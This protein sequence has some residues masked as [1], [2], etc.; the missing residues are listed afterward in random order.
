[1]G[2][3]DREDSRGD[4]GGNNCSD[5]HRSGWRSHVR[6]AAYRSTTTPKRRA[7]MKGGIG[8]RRRDMEFK[9]NC[10]SSSLCSRLKER[11]PIMFYFSRVAVAV[12]QFY[13]STRSCPKGHH[14]HTHAW[15]TCIH[16]WLC[17]CVLPLPCHWVVF[18]LFKRQ[19]GSSHTHD[20]MV[21]GLT[22]YHRVHLICVFSSENS[23]HPA[24]TLSLSSR[25]RLPSPRALLP[26][27]RRSP[28][29][30]PR[31]LPRP[32]V[33]VRVNREED[34]LLVLNITIE[35]HISVPA[36]A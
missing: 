8:S 28:V 25:H 31:H 23:Y 27:P 35:T 3:W 2:E 18:T 10:N 14:T 29:A 12:L 17:V 33:P 34:T 16:M 15:H 36:Y 19:T 22:Y 20:S 1:M 26:A 30:G 6:P 7:R 13:R 32:S 11:F 21:L 5:R 4:N 24:C 9:K